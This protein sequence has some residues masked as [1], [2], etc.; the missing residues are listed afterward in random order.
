MSLPRIILRYLLCILVCG[1]VASANPEI[2]RLLFAFLAFGL[3]VI[4][5]AFDYYKRKKGVRHDN[6]S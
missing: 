4:W 3:L 1:M 6:I 2:P 5:E